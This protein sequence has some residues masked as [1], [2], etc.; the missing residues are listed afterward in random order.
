MWWRDV[1]I[2]VGWAGCVLM[3]LVS[4]RRGRGARHG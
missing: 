2:S 3:V 4:A 1:V